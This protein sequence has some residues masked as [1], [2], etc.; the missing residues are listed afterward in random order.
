MRERP[1][2]RNPNTNSNTTKTTN[3]SVPA[4]DLAAFKL[5][6]HQASYTFRIE[7]FFGTAK[8]NKKF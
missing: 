2:N 3:L 1:R 4:P 6:R 5:N 8:R 7:R